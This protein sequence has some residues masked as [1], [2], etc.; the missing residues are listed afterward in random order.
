MKFIVQYV[1][2]AT[3]EI[4]ANDENAARKIAG[5]SPEEKFEIDEWE[6]CQLYET[7]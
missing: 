1:K 4:E 2:Y 6:F 5:D 3:I 7:E